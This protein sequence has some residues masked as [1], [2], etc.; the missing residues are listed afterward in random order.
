MQELKIS[1]GV[2]ERDPSRAERFQMKQIQEK[3]EKELN[4]QGRPELTV[5]DVIN[6]CK[7][8]FTSK[9]KNRNPV[10]EASRFR[11]G[12]SR[13]TKSSAILSEGTMPGS[14]QKMTGQS[15]FPIPDNDI[16]KKT[17]A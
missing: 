7:Q 1:A 2:K 14:P 4:D 13:K 8:K 17:F 11:Q 9:S 16:L 10:S 3:L 6:E 12:N 5:E 15:K